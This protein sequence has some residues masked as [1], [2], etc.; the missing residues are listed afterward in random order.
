MNAIA[1]TSNR[2]HYP[3]VRFGWPTSFGKDKTTQPSNTNT[4]KNN[5]FLRISALLKSEP[6]KEARLWLLYIRAKSPLIEA[7][8]SDCDKIDAK[9]TPS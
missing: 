4:S 1:T 2:S 3:G 8:K 5:N 9:I 6:S 7:A